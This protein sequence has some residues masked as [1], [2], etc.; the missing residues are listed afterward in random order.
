MAKPEWGAKHRCK[1][2]GKA[3]Y[4]MQRDPIVCPSCG[5]EHVPE[6]LLKPSK[7]E[8]APAEKPKVKPV[9]PVVG[10]DDDEENV[11]LLLDDDEILSEDD[12]DLADDDDDD[13]DLGVVVRGKDDEDL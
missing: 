13:G 3:F 7:A 6:K 8:A 12:V 2:C 10:D 11:D 1:S 4:D 5:T 9:K